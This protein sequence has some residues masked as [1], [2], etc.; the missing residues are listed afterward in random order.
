MMSEYI[1]DLSKSKGEADTVRQNDMQ[2]REYIFNDI[3][4]GIYQEFE[5]IKINHYNL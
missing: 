4:A 5:V 2:G 1:Q 3:T